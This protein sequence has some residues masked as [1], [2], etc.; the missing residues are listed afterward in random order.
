[1]TSKRYTK[2]L[3]AEIK[4]KLT[5]LQFQVTQ[6]DATEPP[7][8]NDFWDN[9]AAGIYVD[10]VTGEPL[11]SS[12]DKFESGTGWP[13][14]TKPIEPGRVVSRTDE[15]LGMTRT[16]VRSAGGN[17]HLGHVF[18]DGPAPTGERYCINSAALRFV[19]VASL[20]REGYGAYG[21]RFASPAG[22]GADAPPPASTDN[23]CAV[24]APGQRAGCE[25]TLDTT[26]LGGDERTAS[27]LRQVPGVLEAKA[28]RLESTAAVRVV[29]DPKELSYPD[30][31]EKWAIAGMPNG[32][33]SRS[34]NA[35][36]TVICASDQQLHEAEEWNTHSLSGRARKN[37]IV[38]RSGD[39]NAFAESKPPVR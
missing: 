23:S 5:P 31:L 24:P 18:D 26:L 13:S 38:V 14:F 7:F 16:E 1:M 33:G 35:E 27:D 9:H 34:G 17:S 8:R 25:T 37:S 3:D 19:P 10:V 29:F 11:F 4:Q 22:A 20:T 32:S 39:P 36:L 30:L 28:G 12:L 15:T 2:P 21:V 6:R